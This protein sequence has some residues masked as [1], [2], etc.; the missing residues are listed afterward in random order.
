MQTRMEADGNEIVF[1]VPV[2][3][4]RSDLTELLADNGWYRGVGAR[5]RQVSNNR[6]LL[7]IAKRLHAYEM[8]RKKMPGLE[9]LF[10]DPAWM[11]LLD[12][13]IR[14]FEDK[15]TTVSSATTASGSTAT[16]GLRYVVEL[17]STGHV[18]RTPHPSDDRC[19]LLSLSCD[20]KRAISDILKSVTV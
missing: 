9:T 17:V 11:I 2:R 5:S 16:T 1:S 4:N 15:T 18:I 10:G 6:S 13:Y 7:D 3:V 20:A 14:E 8:S 12:L 19:I